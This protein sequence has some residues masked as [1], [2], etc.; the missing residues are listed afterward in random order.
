MLTKNIKKYSLVCYLC[1]FIVLNIGFCMFKFVSTMLPETNIKKNIELS[2]L[3]F[4]RAWLY[5]MEPLASSSTYWED[6][7]WAQIDFFTELILINAAYTADSSNA[8]IDGIKN[9]YIVEKN[10]DEYNPLNNLRAAFLLDQFETIEAPQYWWGLVSVYRLLLSVM[11]YNQLL[12]L[13]KLSFYL[14]M[15]ICV[16]QIQKH[17]GMPI[18]LMFTFSLLLGNIPLVAYSPNL[19]I[20]FLIAFLGIL[21]ALLK[22]KTIYD[23]IIIMIFVGSFTAFFDWMT[24]PIITFELIMSFV[25]LNCH[26]KKWIYSFIGGFKLLFISAITWIVTYAGTLMFKWGLAS[27]MLNGSILSIIKKRINDGT[28]NNIGDL[29]SHQLDYIFSTI[30]RNWE[31]LLINRINRTL[32]LI[33]ILV[34]ILLLL[35]FGIRFHKK[36][37]YL[38]FCLLILSLGPIVWYGVLKGHTYV[39]FWFTYRS[40]IGT[41]FCIFLSFVYS[42]RFKGYI[43]RRNPK[44][45]NE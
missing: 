9:P 30:K 1:I 37:I 19:G 43:F 27:Y 41:I 33:I 21:W 44:Q 3:E 7:A 39:H 29:H 14:L 24:T 36:N 12:I 2:Y 23:S 38:S 11:P 45:K 31:P 25:L 42:S 34:L 22:M 17:L 8:F 32:V 35:M 13:F 10:T 5:P 28:N 40:L 16:L 15:F 26:Q 4:E 20:T 6:D 18:A